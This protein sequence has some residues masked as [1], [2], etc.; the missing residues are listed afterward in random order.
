LLDLYRKLEQGGGTSHVP[1]AEQGEEEVEL[2]IEDVRIDGGVGQAEER[3]DGGDQS[4][5]DDDMTN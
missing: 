4:T 3:Q 1:H 2:E 5:T